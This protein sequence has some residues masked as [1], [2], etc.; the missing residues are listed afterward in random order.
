MKVK[1]NVTLAKNGNDHIRVVAFKTNRSRKNSKVQFG[2]WKNGVWYKATR[3]YI[4]DNFLK[5]NVVVWE[6]SDD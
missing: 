6:N 4:Y 1:Y 3:Q 5:R 2:F